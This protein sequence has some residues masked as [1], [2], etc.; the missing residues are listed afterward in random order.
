MRTTNCDNCGVEI[1][2]PFYE[3]C[4]SLM[5]KHTSYVKSEVIH[6]CF[7]CAKKF[8]F[9]KNVLNLK[10]RRRSKTNTTFYNDIEDSKKT[11]KYKFRAF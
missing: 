8:K 10:K 4:V 3:N 2:E 7:N 9:I 11:K 1:E 6:L 5:P